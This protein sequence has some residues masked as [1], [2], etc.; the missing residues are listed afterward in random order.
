MLHT[1]FTVAVLAASAVAN[2]LAPRALPPSGTVSVTPHDMYSS[3]IGVLGCKINTNRVAYWPAPPGCDGMC[4]QLTY[5]GR[6]LYVLHVDQSGGAYD[7][8]YGAWNKLLT[9]QAATVDPQQGGGLTMNYVVVP[10]S[11]CAD[12]LTGEGGKLPLSAANSMNYYASCAAQPS[13]WA[14]KNSALYNIADP[15]CK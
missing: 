5:Q 4:I 3:S 14:A 6:S 11:N 8:S 1:L 2:P 7:I 10:M 12:L 15:V 13:S 9:G